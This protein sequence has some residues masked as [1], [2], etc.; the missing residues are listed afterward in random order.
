MADCIWKP[1]ERWFK[2]PRNYELIMDMIPD[3]KVMCPEYIEWMAEQYFEKRVPQEEKDTYHEYNQ[4]FQDALTAEGAKQRDRIWEKRYY[5][6]R[7]PVES[8]YRRYQSSSPPKRMHIAPTFVPPEY[9]GTPSYDPVEIQHKLYQ[10]HLQQISKE[11]AQQAM[12]KYNPLP[13]MPYA[14]APAKPHQPPPPND[15]SQPFPFTNFD[16]S[17]EPGGVNYKPPQ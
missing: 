11:K 15:Y 8:A 12:Q 2:I 7:K 1:W 3:V 9:N 4:E 17:Y 10:D 16:F 14:Y 5:R 6:I 13:P